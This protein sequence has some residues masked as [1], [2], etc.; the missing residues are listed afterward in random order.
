MGQGSTF[1]LI[2]GT[3]YDWL[4]TALNSYRMDKWDF[5]E[6]IPAGTTANVWLEF[7]ESIFHDKSDD[8]GSVQYTLSGT[9]AT[10]QLWARAPGRKYTLQADLDGIAT[11]NNAQGST[12][13]L[14][15]TDNGVTPFILSGT[16]DKLSSSNPPSDWMQQNLSTLGHRQ[17]RH[18]CM[19]GSHDSGMSIITGHTG[20][21]DPAITL[22]QTNDIGGQLALGARYFDIR[23]IIA[24]GAYKT[25]HYSKI[26]V[27]V[28]AWQGADGQVVQDIVRQINEFTAN[29]AELIVLNLSHDLNTDMNDREYRAM[30]Q[31]EWDSLFELLTGI[32]HLFVFETDPTTVDLSTLTLNQFIG[33]GQAAVVAIVEPTHIDLGEYAHR[34]F[35]RYS[36]FDIYNSYANTNDVDN[37]V[38]D[39]LDKMRKQR[40]SPDSP[41]FLLSWT[42][43]QRV[44]NMLEGQTIIGLSK[45][46]RW[47]IFTRLLPTCSPETYPN[48]LYLDNW[49]TSDFTALAM[50]INDM[51]GYSPVVGA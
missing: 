15:W 29:N 47:A 5:P 43:T 2:N 39:Q 21:A 3:A 33:T 26:N 49:V 25:G 7:D 45:K 32:T 14:G 48:V 46:A 24:A 44:D 27:E 19:P 37:M 16:L 30:N 9:S 11:T 4:R 28:I 12:I 35:Y 1:A 41:L 20:F 22:T 36:Q 40:A 6:S 13:N 51:V 42:L 18:L 31:S 17:L 10:F 38:S 50:A 23:P 34:G 8:A